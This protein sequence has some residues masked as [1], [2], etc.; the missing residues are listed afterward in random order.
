M[1]F[2]FIHRKK[3]DHHFAATA[4]TFYIPFAQQL[5]QQQR[6]RNVNNET[7]FV[8]INGCQGSGKSTLV[9]FLTLFLRREF[10]LV[11]VALSLDDFYLSKVKREH[12][13]Q[14]SHPLFATR[15]VPG[16]HNINLLAATL[17]KL[18]A[19]KN[20]PVAIALPRFNKA[21]DDVCARNAWHE[22]NQA[23]DIVL[24]EGWCWG[25]P[26]QNQVDLVLPI[27]AL[28]AQYDKQAV[29]RRQVNHNLCHDY[30]PLYD[31]MDTWLMLKAPSFEVVYQWRLQQEKQLAALGQINKTRVN[32]IMSEKQVGEFIQHY[33][34]LTE[35]SLK[36]MPDKVEVLFTLDEQR[37]IIASKG[38]GG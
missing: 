9:E 35:H 13:A 7:L 15:G 21:L 25:V 29:W 26:A 10:N 33:Q 30:Q 12:L 4:E 1:L 20:E 28:E 5:V 17:S 27:N 22:V 3:L 24:F 32:K 18:K 23:V 6:A 8:G 11:V 31:F 19:S 34:R 16:T 36:V 37:K 2:D 14:S 38:L